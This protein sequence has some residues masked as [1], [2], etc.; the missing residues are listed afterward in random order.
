MSARA[1]IL[2]EPRFL[3]LR[4]ALQERLF[5][6]ARGV[7]PENFASLLDPLMREILCQSFAEAGADE[8]TVWLVD[9]EEKCLVPAYNS[10]PDAARFVGQFRLA[11]TEGLISMVFANEQPFVENEAFENT[12]QDKRLDNMLG[13]RTL[14][15]I[16]VPFYFL[17]SCRG[18]VSCVQLARGNGPSSAKSPFEPGHL[19]AV[20]RGA[21][22]VSRLIDLSLISRTIGWE[23][24]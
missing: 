11:L 1:T 13:V 7:L 12:R 9:S 20:Q 6:V 2:P 8:G 3:E 14:G 23:T 16:A 19:A 10:G 17:K 24:E 5:S 18:V 15:L 21:T 4:E 22:T